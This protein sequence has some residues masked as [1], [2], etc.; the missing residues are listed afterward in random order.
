MSHVYTTSLWHCHNKIN[1]GHKIPFGVFF[2]TRHENDGR[3][4][5]HKDKAA[6]CTH[7]LGRYGSLGKTAASMWH[8]QCINRQ[9]R[10]PD[11][12]LKCREGALHCSC[13][14]LTASFWVMPL[15]DI[16]AP[17]WHTNHPKMLNIT[18]TKINN[19]KVCHQCLRFYRCLQF[20]RLWGNQI[21]PS[22]SL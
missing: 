13:E 16:Y 18:H 12:L 7:E 9:G 5:G 21:K 1:I 17:A 6:R 22:K 11:I 15:F 3:Q 20:L 14:K 4:W 10:L 19:T 8:S 2:M